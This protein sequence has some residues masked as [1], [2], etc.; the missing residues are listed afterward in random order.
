MSEPESLDTNTSPP[1]SSEGAQSMPF[2]S[3]LSQVVTGIREQ[4]FLFVIAIVILLISLVW[5]SRLESPDL[6]FVVVI[7]AVLAF[8]A[9]LGYWVQAV[10]TTRAELKDD[11][12]HTIQPTQQNRPG[13]A[14]NSA[15]NQSDNTLQSNIESLQREQKPTYSDEHPVADHQLSTSHTLTTSQRRELEKAL[16]ACASVQ[17]RSTRDSIVNDL[18]SE[19]RS[20]IK[21]HES[22][23][24]DVSNIVKTSL[25]FPG[26]LQELINTVRNYEGSNIRHGSS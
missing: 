25:S 1:N 24:V 13:I 2:E 4:P 7:I 19:I 17:D 8:A 12:P 14:S 3:T 5:A 23:N 18:P 26:G 22:E 9:L 11:E 15:L 6:R 21:R 20:R 10:I 16:R